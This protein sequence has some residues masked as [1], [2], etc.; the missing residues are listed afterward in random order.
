[1]KIDSP[2]HNTAARAVSSNWAFHKPVP[3]VN[4]EAVE[5]TEGAKGE[6]KGE[7]KAEAMM[8]LQEASMNMQDPQ[9]EQAA[10]LKPRQE[11]VIPG[12]VKDML[13]KP[14]PSLIPKELEAKDFDEYKYDH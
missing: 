3:G 6:A 10:L 8:G 5:G 14:T 7:P 11:T 4:D 9:I 2:T 13:S 1:M 12:E